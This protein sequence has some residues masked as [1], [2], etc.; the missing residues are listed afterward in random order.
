[1]IG[2]MGGTVVFRFRHGAMC[3]RIASGYLHWGSSS[4]HVFSS[5]AWVCSHRD[6]LPQPTKQD[7]DMLQLQR[8]RCVIRFK[9][10]GLGRLLP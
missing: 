9:G 4:E 3:R 7:T 2:L 6:M 8:D 10:Q 1:M 5:S